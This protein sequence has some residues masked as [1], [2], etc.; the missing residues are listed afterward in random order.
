MS[1]TYEPRNPHL[2][3]LPPELLHMIFGHLEYASDVNSLSQTY[4]RLSSFFV[5]RYSPRGFEN[6]INNGNAASARK[7]FSS[8]KFSLEKYT[9]TNESPEITA[10]DLGHLEML[11]LIMDKM[12]S[13]A[14]SFKLMFSAIRKDHLHIISYSVAE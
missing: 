5:E 12:S 1:G 9:S 4:E 2:Q 11:K 13:T 3:N 10:A 6:V 8:P 7:L 14:D